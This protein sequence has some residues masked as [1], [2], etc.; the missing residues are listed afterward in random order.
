VR[1][2]AGVVAAESRF[3]VI[4]F[5]MLSIQVAEWIGTRPSRAQWSRLGPGLVMYVALSFLYNTLLLQSA[6]IRL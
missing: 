5:A 4:G 1:G 2:F 6:D 3:G